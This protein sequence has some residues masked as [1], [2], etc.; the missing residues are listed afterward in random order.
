MN[1]DGIYSMRKMTKKQKKTKQKI[2]RKEKLFNYHQVFR[3]RCFKSL[4]ANSMFCV[5]CCVMEIA[6]N[7]VAG[8]G[9]WMMMMMKK[10]I[11]NHLV[12]QLL[13]QML[14]LSIHCIH[15]LVLVSYKIVLA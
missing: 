8:C 12:I 9:R 13:K 7:H 14:H 11:I 15:F 6:V 3:L 10:L 2:M 4:F 5:V 1:N